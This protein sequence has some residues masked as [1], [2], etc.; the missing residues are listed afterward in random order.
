MFA[1]RQAPLAF[2]VIIRGGT[3]IDGSG[4]PRFVADVG[5]IRGYIARVGSLAG[6]SAPIEIDATGLYVTPGFI[7][8]HSHAT[9]EGLP[10][11]VNMLVQGVTTE[12]LNADGGGP[13]DLDT[14]LHRLRVAG[15]AVNAGANIGFNAIWSSVIGTSDRRPTADEITRMREMVQR[16]LEQGAYG[17]S[18]G[19]DYKPGYY[20]TAEEVGRVIDV[21]KPWRTNFP[22][23]DRLTPES[24][25]SSRVGIAETLAIGAR[26]GLVPV[27]T[28]MKVQ[29]REQGTA[30]DVLRMMDDAAAKGT[31]VAAD[32]YPYLAGQSGLAAL[33]IPGWALDGGRDAMLARFASLGDRAR[34]IKE[35]EEAMMLRFG[36]PQGVY[37][38]GHGKELTDAMREFGTASPGEALLRLLE[39]QDGGAILRFGSESDLVAI[40]KYP[41]ASIA[42]DCG[43]VAGRAT[44]PR[45]YGSF[46]RVLGRY[47]R[48]QQALTWEDAI[49]K[50]SGLPAATIGLVNRG[51]LA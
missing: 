34:I 8:I 44:H 29:G 13:T 14:Q 41:S 26:S 46:P 38:T 35:A 9:A 22:N 50:M 21:A 25:Y 12:I 6:Q 49:R 16:G 17:V 32:V 5:I 2:D 15:L 42:C 7:N 10:T 3:V 40:M 51:Q 23:H 19:L 48:E 28:H 20:A 1:Q 45:Y 36:G 11:A 30:A 31:Y 33:L 39:Q 43:A 37:A 18:A 47:V 4:A 27:V 24:K